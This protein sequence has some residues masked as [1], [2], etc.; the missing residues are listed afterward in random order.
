DIA[1]NVMTLV[2]LMGVR[3]RIALG[4][5]L[6]ER[7]WSPIV[8]AAIVLDASRPTQTVWRGTLEELASD[9]LDV[10]HDGGGTVLVGEGVGVS[11]A[12]AS[13]DRLQGRAPTRAYLVKREH[14]GSS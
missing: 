6:I 7:G 12:A 1:P 9:R 13:S 3:R 11:G 4:R 2:I 10:E 14:Y 8:P 5:E